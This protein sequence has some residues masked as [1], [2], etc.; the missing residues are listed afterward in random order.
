MPDTAPPLMPGLIS[1]T[2]S[3]SEAVRVYTRIGCL[4]F[5]GP[6]GQIALMHREFVDRLGWVEEEHFLHALNFCH[7]LPGPEAQQLATWIGWKLHGVRGGVAA[8]LLFILP[9]ALVMALLSILYVVAADLDWFVA[10]FLGVKAAVLAIIAQALL[11]IGGR[12]L[13]TALRRWIALA[14][15]IAIAAFAVPFPFIIL[16]A[17]VIGYAAARWRPGLLK[18]SVPS[19]AMIAAPPSK[20]WGQS[21]RAMVQWGLAWTLPLI[22]ILVT[23]GRSHILWD[24]AL[25][26]SQLAMVTFGGAYAV[27]AYMA[28]EAVNGMG[29]LSAGEMA[30]GLGLAETTPGPLILVTQF[31]GFLAAYHDAAPFTPML[32][33]LIGAAVTLW[34]TFVP[35]FLWIFTFAPWIDQMERAPGLKGALAAVTAAVVGVIANL[36]LWFAL[37]LFFARVEDA[38]WGFV[39]LPLPDIATVQWDAVFLSI[40]A[41]LLL[42]RFRFGII[43]MLGICA[44]AGLLLDFV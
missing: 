2:P 29:W 31:V 9:G 44:G 38:R 33:G 8:G 15:L 35:C 36:S 34:V 17:L 24:I 4:N 28:Q 40:L 7:L 22:L 41:A 5:G 1:N 6:V 14:A 32:A 11:R 39:S 25:F 12:A 42:F 3:F 30:D 43:S 13:T 37:H 16:A 23:V 26:F 10:A 19:S 27:L 21:I 18:I 20:L